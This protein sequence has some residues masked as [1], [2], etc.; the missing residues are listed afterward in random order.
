MKL[1]FFS[2]TFLKSQVTAAL[3]TTVD[4]VV[5]VLLVELFSVWYVLAAAIAG[6]CGA[7][8]SFFLGRHWTFLS[9]DDKWH[10][11][12]QRYTLVAAG[13]MALNTIGIYILTDGLDLHYM[14]SKVTMSIIVSLGF[15]Y[16][17]Q[18]NFVFRK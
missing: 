2:P 14:V 9:K 15:N 10:H 8:S 17:M 7:L 1:T 13:S 16:P 5:I 11:Q 6:F 3:A 12:A 18:K 4:F